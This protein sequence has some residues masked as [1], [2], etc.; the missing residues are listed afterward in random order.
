MTV[1]QHVEDVKAA[2]ALVRAHPM[3]AQFV[4]TSQHFLALYPPGYRLGGC[5]VSRGMGL[6]HA[7]GVL[8]SKMEQHWSEEQIGWKDPP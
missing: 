8:L 7:L 1:A 6:R 5:R 3:C 4:K 2:E